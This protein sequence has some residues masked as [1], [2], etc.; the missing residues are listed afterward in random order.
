MSSHVYRRRDY[1]IITPGPWS[2]WQGGAV[3][4]LLQISPVIQPRRRDHTRTNLEPHTQQLQ[5]ISSICQS[6]SETGRW[7]RPPDER[8]SLP[9]HQRRPSSL[10]YSTR[11]FTHAPCGEAMWSR[12][13]QVPDC[14]SHVTPRRRVLLGLVTPI[15]LSPR[16]WWTTVF[17]VRR[18]PQ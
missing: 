6:D 17:E 5:C 3:L 1:A 7:R 2:D 16:L 15:L 18:R 13:G 4:T 10:S 12:G 11:H 14:H 9:R 8:R